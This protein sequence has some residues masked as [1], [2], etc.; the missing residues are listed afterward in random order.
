[1]LFASIHASTQVISLLGGTFTTRRP[2]DFEFLGGNCRNTRMPLN[3][4]GCGFELAKFTNDQI[5]ASS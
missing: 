5:I 3:T 1:M 4:S 2:Q